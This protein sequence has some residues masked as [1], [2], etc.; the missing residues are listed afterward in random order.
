M[1]TITDE[2]I[3]DK[4]IDLMELHLLTEAQKIEQMAKWYRE[5]M[6][7]QSVIP[8]EIDYKMQQGFN[9]MLDEIIHKHIFPMYGGLMATS[10]QHFLEKGVV[11]GS[12]RTVLRAML[13]EYGDI[14]EKS[15]DR[16]QDDWIDCKERLP[17]NDGVYHVYVN[18]KVTTAL[19][20]NGKFR[21]GRWVIDNITHWQPLPTAP[22]PKEELK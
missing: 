2:E 1:K 7:E 13:R 3:N 4:I 11:S 14:C 12:F 21:V 10:I 9:A 19:F 22:K 16:K 6:G 5:Q 20:E 15:V 18:H 17:E 8:K